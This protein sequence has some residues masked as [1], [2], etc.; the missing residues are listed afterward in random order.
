MYKLE[1][2][3]RIQRIE[4]EFG[5]SIPKI[6]NELHWDKNLKH[7]EIGERINVP[8]STVTKWFYH[9]EIDTQDSH[10]FTNQNLLNVGCKKGPRAQPRPVK[11]DRYRIKREFFKSW[12]S[13][14]AYVLGYFAADGCM[15][16]NPRGSHY[17]E[18]TST[19]RELIEKVRRLL[20]SNHK[21]GTYKHSNPRWKDKYV[22]QIGSKDMFQDL[23][24]LGFCPRKSKRLR[25][26]KIP[27]LYLRHFVRGYFDGDG[28]VVFKSYPRKNRRSLQ[29][30]FAVRFTSGSQDFLHELKFSLYKNARTKG[31]SIYDKRDG[32]FEL[33]FSTKDSLRLFSFMY[34]SVTP[35]EYL[36]RKHSTFIE[37]LMGA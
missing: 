9:F 10:R 34:K 8:R 31:G 1:E 2:S 24:K 17:F 26:P 3:E 16:V 22:L 15:F 5:E 33:A 12:S 37:A 36:E 13:G 4:E 19:D 7:S 27:K 25:F 29:R 18:F 11:L 35:E 30:I 14:M 20:G 6:L 28:H 23:L 21:I 32:S